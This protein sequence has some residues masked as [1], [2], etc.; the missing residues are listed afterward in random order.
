MLKLITLGTLGYLGY[1]LWQQNSA[2]KPD[3]RLAGGPLSSNAKLQST[4]DA[5]P[6][7]PPV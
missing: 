5:P 6:F 1:R 3:L 4:A 2:E 7:A